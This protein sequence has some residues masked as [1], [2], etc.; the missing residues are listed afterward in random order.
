MACHG[1][2]RRIKEAR[3]GRNSCRCNGALPLR[4]RFGSEDPQ[5]R[6]RDEV[7]LKVECVVDDGM[8]AEKTLRRSGR[9]ETLHLALAPPHDLMGILS[10]IV[11][12]E[13]LL[14]RTNQAK[15]AERRAIG[16]QLVG[17][18]KFRHKALLLEKL[19]QQP[20]GCALVAPALNQYVQDFA[21]VID[22]SP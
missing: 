17:H 8:E 1:N 9:L 13:P 11:L 12:S 20:E 15:V 4:C 22:G 6:S 19:A 5:R 21:L 10:A 16:A 18:Q 3:A 14:M 7:A 2:D